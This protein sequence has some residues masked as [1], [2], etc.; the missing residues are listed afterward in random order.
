[1]SQPRATRSRALQWL[2]VVS[3]TL[4]VS[5][6][7][8]T[9]Q[10]ASRQP[11]SPPPTR[12]L[13][14][15]PATRPPSVPTALPDVELLL[16]ALPTRTPPPG[17][18]R[19]ARLE[20]ERLG[21]DAV[22]LAVGVDKDGRIVTPDRYAGYWSM[23]APLNE[24]GNTVIVG[25]NKPDPWPVFF[26]LSRADVGDEVKVTDQF[27]QEYNYRVDE[28]VIIQVEGAPPEEAQRTL[29][30]IQPTQSRR[31]TLITCYPDPSCPARLVVVATPED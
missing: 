31:L 10:R 13:P 8:L 7:V 1:M 12:I 23:S 25:H 19:P 5:A 27:G 14:A 22:V 3:L 15:T 16:T 30:F 6:L 18:A 9:L 24:D 26:G 20:M 29:E 28:S 21:I 2:V 11:P 17:P 4:L